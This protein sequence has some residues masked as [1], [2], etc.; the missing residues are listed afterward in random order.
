M[1]EKLFF[2]IGEACKELDIQPYVLR[3]WETEFPI[4]KPTKSKSGQRVYSRSDL[5]MIRRIKELL[6]DEGFTIAGAKKKLE[7]D[8]V[9]AVKTQ[10]KPREVRVGKSPRTGVKLS[11]KPLR[12]PS[13]KPAA[14]S[15]AMKASKSKSLAQPKLDRAA[16][17]EV[18]LLRSGIR[19]SIKEARAI[20]SILEGV[21]PRD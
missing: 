3:Y 1:T 4:L 11:R 7:E 8:R 10:P 2:K 5:H 13:S 6:Y 12:R 20:L 17:K 21:S 9:T 18:K 15:P 14:K 19:D 16:A